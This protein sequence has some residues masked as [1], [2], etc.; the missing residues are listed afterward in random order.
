MAVMSRQESLSS[1]FLQYFALPYS[2]SSQRS[3]FAHFVAEFRVFGRRAMFWSFNSRNCR[4]SSGGSL[5]P[6]KRLA[7]SMSSVVRALSWSWLRWRW[8]RCHR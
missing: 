4:A 3:G 5:R 2:P 8:L 7:C 6:S 1:A